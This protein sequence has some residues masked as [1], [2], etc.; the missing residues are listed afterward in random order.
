VIG[1]EEQLLST[2]PVYATLPTDDVERLRQFYERLG[3]V[4]GEQTDAGVYLRAADGTFFAVTRSSGRPSGTHT[5]LGFRV[6]QIEEVVA[7]LRSRGVTMEEYE[8]PRTVGGIADIPIGRA[9]W[10]KDP[11]GNIVGLLELGSDG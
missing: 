5:Q 4:V 2:F 1:E 8:T 10:F 6:R 9:A 7:D 11:D 3:F